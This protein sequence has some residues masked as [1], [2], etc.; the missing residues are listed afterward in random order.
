MI[1]YLLGNV[2]IPDFLMRAGIRHFVNIRK[3][4]IYR[5][6]YNEPTKLAA[7]ADKLKAMPVAV[8][9]EQA[10]EQHYEVPAGFYEKVLGHYLKYSCCSWEDATNL[11]AAEQEML[12]AYVKKAQIE[13]GQHILDMGCGWGSFSL[14]ASSRFSDLK[15]TAVSNSKSQKAYIDQRAK[16]LGLDKKITVVTANIADYEAE[17]GSF[18]RVVSIEMLEHVKN[19]EALFAR[20]A[21]WLKNDGKF[22]AHIFTHSFGA[23]HFEYQNKSDWMSKYFFSGGMMP[24]EDLFHHFQADLKLDHQ[25][26]LSGKHY[27]KTARAWLENMDRQRSDIMAIFETTYG[28]TEALKWW[29]YWRV[30]F[31]ACEELWAFR[32]GK[33]WTVSHYLFSK[34]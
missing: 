20:I 29:R 23:Y 4:E 1:D 11:D 17:A 32:S 8:C 26:Q 30:F 24:A 13:N 31:M 5:D 25:W 22:F 15:I 21:S 18:D 2:P 6:F 28:P 16:T 19:Y 33:E 12:D 34:K 3:N 7:F 27:A 10:N 14:Y 9:T